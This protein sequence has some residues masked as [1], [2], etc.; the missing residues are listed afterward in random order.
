MLSNGVSCRLFP[1][2]PVG[3]K[4]RHMK[5]RRAVIEHRAVIERRSPNRPTNGTT[6]LCPK[7]STHNVEF[8]ERYRL[9]NAKG[10][11]VVTPAWICESPVCGYHLAVRNEDDLLENA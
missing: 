5:A 8:N 11:V 9:P 1:N 2:S 10:I 4:A 7:C 6:A 3:K